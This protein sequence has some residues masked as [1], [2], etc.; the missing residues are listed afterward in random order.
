MGSD[1]EPPPTPAGP[2]APAANLPTADRYPIAQLPAPGSSLDFYSVPLAVVTGQVAEIVRREGP[3]HEWDVMVRVA[4]AWGL[5]RVGSQIEARV[6]AAIDAAGRGGTIA[7]KDGFL[8]VPGAPARVRS[9]VGTDIPME[10]VPPEEVQ[11]AIRLVLAAVRE[12]PRDQLVAHVRG[13]FGFQRT[14]QRIESW[15]TES[16]R[17]MVRDGRIG[18]GPQGLGLL[19]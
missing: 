4:G 14:G 7:R 19:G 11:E 3:V 1:P 8:A 9:R 6:G 15:I 10:R 18:E 16:V 12:A 17:S 2:P 13:L 5:Q